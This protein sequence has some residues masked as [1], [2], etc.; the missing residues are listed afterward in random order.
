MKPTI[1]FKKNTRSVFFHITTKCN[2]SCKHCYIDPDQHGSGSVPLE[3][4]IQWLTYLKKNNTDLVLLGGEP[5]LHPDLSEVVKTARK[6]EYRSI[7]IDTN[8]YLFHDIL[9]QVTPLDVDF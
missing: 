3:E 6:L 5:T 1:L 7:T 4:I 8:G 2:L 9:N